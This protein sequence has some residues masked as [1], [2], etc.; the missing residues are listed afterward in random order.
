MTPISLMSK[1]SPRA[2]GGLASESTLLTVSSA[3]EAE[4]QESV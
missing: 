2:A 1:L 3:V 4:P